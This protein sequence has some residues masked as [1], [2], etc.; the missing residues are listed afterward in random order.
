MTWERGNRNATVP[1]TGIGAL[2]SGCLAFRYILTEHSVNYTYSSLRNV[3]KPGKVTDRL[4]GA[5]RRQTQ[6]SS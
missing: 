3:R 6:R 5:P 1:V 2:A 4:M